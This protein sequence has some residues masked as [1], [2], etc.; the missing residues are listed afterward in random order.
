MRKLLLA[1]TALALIVGVASAQTKN[2]SRT[3][4][5]NT[6]A[7]LSTNMQN[8]SGV[9]YF[10]NDGKTVIAFKNNTGAAVTGTVITQRSSV[11][12]EGYSSVSLSN[13][14]ISIPSA[15]TVLAGPYPAAQWNTSQG[16]VGISL[17]SAVG[18]SATALKVR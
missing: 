3:D 9:T 7:N 17:T 15:S 6:G 1:T 11:T 5:V 2:V 16:T 10:E 12:K 13:A 18:I 14:T 8:A 4:L